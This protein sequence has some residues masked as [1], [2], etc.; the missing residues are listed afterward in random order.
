V[1]LKPLLLDVLLVINILVSIFIL[2]K[3][4]YTKEPL[5]FSVFPSL[6]LIVTL[7]RLALNISS[8]RL[9]LS[10]NGNAGDVIKTF[11]NF[12]IGDN[13]V[14]GLIIFLIIILIQFIVITKGAERIAEVAAR[15]TLD[16][17]PGKQMAIDADLNA[18]LI[19]ETEAKERRKKVQREADFYGA[20]DGASKFV[21]GDAIVGIIITVINIVGGILIGCLGKNPMPLDKVVSV[22]TLATVGDGLVTQLPALLVSTASGIIVTRVGSSNN[23]GEDFSRQILS[24]PAILI[25]GGVILLFISLIPGLPKIPIFVLAAL[26]IVL[27]Y[28][29]FKSYNRA[30]IMSEEKNMEQMAK[31]SRKP[32]SIMSLLN[33]EPIEIEFGYSIIPLADAKKGGDLLDRVY[34][35]R[36]Q[37]A[38]D[39]GIIIPSIRLRDN[40]QLRP[41]EYVV[42]IKGIEVA[43]G[44]VMI[45]HYLAMNTSNSTEEVE[46]IETREAAFGLPALWIA[47]KEKER[48]ELLGYTV[49][50]PPTVIA[51]HLTEVIKKHSHELMGRQ[52]VQMLLDNVRKTNPV[53][54]DEV[55]PKV[56][57]LGKLQKV[58]INLLKE[59]ISIR[60]MITIIETLGDYGAITD[61]T[62]LLTEYVRQSLKRV[63][64]KKFVPDNNKL[65]VITIDPA[66]EQLILS[67]IQQTEHGSYLNIEPQTVQKIIG[68]MKKAADKIVSLGI[69][70]IVLTAPVVRQHLKKITEQVIPDLIVL[71]FSEL[72]HGVEIQSDSV[73]T[74]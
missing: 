39:L 46:G 35:I 31:E 40:I 67:S 14:V 45:S 17:M 52:H 47:E 33:I 7:Y 37:C 62:D 13:L 19:E 27:G 43:R 21:K 70:P 66:L 58:L 5:Q 4:L 51:T 50:D 69:A 42:K 10:N 64:T 30:K 3:T 2:L 71:S 23:L 24:Q 59:N 26:T 73:V 44:E 54:V 34:M 8:T 60:D 12:V 38:L 53:L 57:P 16:A 28:T 32:E 22:Y 49:V 15:F 68:N 56:I 63:I 25:I 65:R 29:L 61:D 11:G 1:P 48:A 18:G 9:I 72:E 20:M 74:A 6:L 36:R 41:S 55:V